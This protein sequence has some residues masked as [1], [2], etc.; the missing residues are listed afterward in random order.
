MEV[1]PYSTIPVCTTYGQYSAEE[2]SAEWLEKAEE[3]N[4]DFNSYT[5]KTCAWGISLGNQ[6]CH[7]AD[8]SLHLTWCFY[9]L[10]R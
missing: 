3:S 6:L 4:D 9:G 10:V 8:K 7:L 5:I 2:Q 1:K